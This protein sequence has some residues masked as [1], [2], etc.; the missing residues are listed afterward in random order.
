MSHSHPY[1]FVFRMLGMAL[2][3]VVLLAVWGCGQSGE[4]A[5]ATSV[6]EGASDPTTA[7]GTPSATTAVEPD[8][9]PS[10][11]VAIDPAPTPSAT[12]DEVLEPG[13]TEDDEEEQKA[14]LERQ[15]QARLAYGIE[16]APCRPPGKTGIPLPEVALPA[17]GTLRI[18]V[19]FVDFAEAEAGYSTQEEAEQG[20]PYMEHYLEVSSYGKLDVEFIA[21]HRWLRAEHDRDS[22]NID[23]TSR[24]GPDGWEKVGVTIQS[25][26][27]RLANPEFDFSQIDAILVVMPSEHY[28]GGN[29]GGGGNKTEAGE[30]YWA[31]VVNS[32]N[33]IGGP[34]GLMP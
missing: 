20:L 31:P 25:E 2:V 18:A 4:D 16:Y 30:F 32:M 22:Y 34:E 6:P 3:L 7:L 27:V 13:E 1:P 10:A 23:G 17:V 15:Q 12:N 33:I 29:S 24:W 28:G 9:T 19:L 14:E 5:E 11:T 21:L 26:A 8:P